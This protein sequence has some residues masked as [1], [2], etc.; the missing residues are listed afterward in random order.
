MGNAKATVTLEWKGLRALWHEAFGLVNHI[1]V[2]VS[3][4]GAIRCN[5]TTL[6]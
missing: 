6:V 4:T 2:E 1:W 3:A 5:W